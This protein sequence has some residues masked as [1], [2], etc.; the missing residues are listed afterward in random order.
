ME[1][2]E[3]TE[4]ISFQ[5]LD[6]NNDKIA[7]QDGDNNYSYSELNKRINQIATGLL[8]DKDDLNEERIAFLIPGSLDYVIWCVA[9]RRHCNTI[10]RK[11]RD[12]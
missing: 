11:F 2:N 1:N 6:D 10:K 8:G 4:M 9:C 5:H 12:S 7:L 3:K